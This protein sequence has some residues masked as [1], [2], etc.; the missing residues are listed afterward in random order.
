MSNY[1]S[2]K[3]KALLSMFA[4]VTVATLAA[5]YTALGA[6]RAGGSSGAVGMAGSSR[7]HFSRGFRHGR[8]FDG[9]GFDGDGFGGGDVSVEQS[10]PAPNVAP[11]PPVNRRYVQPRWVDGGYG[12]EVLESGYWTDAEKQ[13]AH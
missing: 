2:R 1:T 5:P 4:L 6:G 3:K 8:F 13:P 7:Q 9:D 11:E 10:Q 12:V